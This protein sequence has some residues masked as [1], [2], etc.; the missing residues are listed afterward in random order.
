MASGRILPAIS[1]DTLQ[2][3]INQAGSPYAGNTIY[4]A[5][6]YAQLRLETANGT[7]N[8]FVNNNNLFGM[9][10]S[11]QRTQYWESESNSGFAVYATKLRSVLDRVDW[12][13]AHGFTPPHTN[14]DIADYVNSVMRAGYCPDSGYRDR[15]EAI[16]SEYAGSFV[17]SYPNPAD[18]HGVNEDGHGGADDERDGEGEGDGDSLFGFGSGNG[19]FLSATLFGV[20]I[21]LILLGVAAVVLKPWRW[22]NKPQT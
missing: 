17:D 20:P 12:D 13:R 15:W 21:W 14:G 5:I 3:Y 7:S 19:G 9:R 16:I 1:L 2:G 8:N 4:C 6:L 11:H 10:C 18:T 22:F